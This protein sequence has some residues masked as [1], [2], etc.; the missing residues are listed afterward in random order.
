MINI[1]L[2]KKEKPS[3][4]NN[5]KTMY[6]RTLD[7]FANET[8]AIIRNEEEIR[9]IADRLENIKKD[10]LCNKLNLT[11]IEEEVFKEVFR[12]IV[13]LVTCLEELKK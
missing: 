11:Y 10:I 3:M 8:K 6:G 2:E 4:E 13:G 7:I 1:A 9:Y 5:L 12:E